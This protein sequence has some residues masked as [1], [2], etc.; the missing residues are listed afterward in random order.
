[1]TGSEHAVDAFAKTMRLDRSSVTAPDL[2]PESAADT[3]RRRA[4]RPATRERPAHGTL[5]VASVIIAAAI[6]V[7]IA[8]T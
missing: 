6:A 5:V 4:E 8:L 1:M 3:S 2:P 7:V